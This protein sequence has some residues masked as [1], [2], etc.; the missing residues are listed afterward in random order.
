MA[1]GRLGAGRARRRLARPSLTR[2]RLGRL[3]LAVACAVAGL[4]YGALLD[5]SVMVTYGGEQ[6]LDRY[7]ALSAR[8]IPF[9]VAHAAGNFAIALAAGPAL[10][11]MISRFRTRLEFTWRPAGA[12]PAGARRAARS[13]ALARSRAG[14]ERGRRR[15]RR[16]RGLARAGAERRRRLRG[17]RGPALEPG[18]DRLGDARPRGGRARTRSTSQRG[19]ETPVVLPARA[20]STGCARSATSSA[21]SSPSRRPAST[22]AGSPG[23]DLVA[24]LRRRRDGDGS[25]DG[26]VNLTAFYALA[27]RAAGADAALAAAA[28]RLAARGP[29]RR[30][31][32]GHPARRRRA[33]PTRPAPRSRRWSP[34]ERRARRP[35][36]GARWLRKAQR[37]SGG[38]ALGGSGVV[39][40]QSTAWA[41]QGLVAAGGGRR[42]QTERALGYLSR[43]R[44]ADGHYRYSAS[45]DQ[46]PV[47]VTAQALLAVERTA[48]PLV[49]VAPDEPR[50]R[51]ADAEL[52]HRRRRR[53][54]A[55]R[56]TEAPRQAAA[57]ASAGGPASAAERDAAA[58]RRRRRP[59]ARAAATAAAAGSGSGATTGAERAD[60]AATARARRRARSPRSPTPRRASRS[61]SAS[62]TSPSRPRATRP[63]A[64]VL[65]AVAAL[66]IAATAGFLWYRRRRPSAPIRGRRRPYQPAGR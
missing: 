42:R 5:L 29:E 55:A 59:A 21:R 22:R 13:P 34:R 16:R 58:R 9:N 36:R 61:R 7:L 15:G 6:S 65:A 41:V 12:L 11:R 26:Q 27:M 48:F 49:A 44:A 37:P 57:P 24:E 50:S 43:L 23:T 47:W 31:R 25:V 2:R 51:G 18:D 28:R 39:N 62:R 52:E 54:D 38:F 8:G 33:R 64:I 32:L 14:S 19:G 40:S 46:T 10:V 45:S 20:R 66:A 35:T 30:R 17:H 4:A 63:T 1:D 56:A 3:G 53:E 60:P